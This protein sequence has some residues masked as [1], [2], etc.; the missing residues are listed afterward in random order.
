MITLI[1]FSNTSWYGFWWQFHAEW[2]LQ[3]E[4]VCYSKHDD[5]NIAASPNNH[6]KLKKK[7]DVQRWVNQLFFAPSYSFIYIH[8]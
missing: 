2:K 1:I 4:D 7:C 8:T 3:N 6:L 5:E